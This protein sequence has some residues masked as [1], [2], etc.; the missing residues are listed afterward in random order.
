MLSHSVDV[1]CPL[2]EPL[3]GPECLT[4]VRGG[5]RWDGHLH[6]MNVIIH[7]AFWLMQEHTLVTVKSRKSSPSKEALSTEVVPP[8]RF[9]LLVPW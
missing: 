1:V 9:R 3:W 2:N 8:R 4:P 6:S 5:S 7:A